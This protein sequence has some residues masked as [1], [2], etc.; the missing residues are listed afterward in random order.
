MRGVAALVEQGVQAMSA[1]AYLIRLRQAGKVNPR[2]QPFAL[3]DKRRHRPV[4]KAVFILAWANQQIEIHLRTAKTDVQPFETVDPTFQRLS[5]RE[6]GIQLAGYV[7]G[8]GITQVPG[9]QR[10]RALLRRQLLQ[11]A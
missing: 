7:T 8:A 11:A 5:K 10:L 4:H 6:I 1:A 3:L 9:F 2:R